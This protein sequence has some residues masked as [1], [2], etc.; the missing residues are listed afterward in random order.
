MGIEI[1]SWLIAIP[2]LG[3]ATGMRSMT[4]MA[5]LCWFAYLGNLSMEGTWAAWTGRRYVAIV[6]TVLAVGELV[7]DKLPKIPAR[8]SFAP[9][10]WRFLLGGLAGSI[11]ATSLNGPGVEGVLL[12]LGGVAVGAFGGYMVRRDLGE[13]FAC[14]DWPVA[15]A[16]DLMAV[17]FSIYALH[18]ITT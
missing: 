15:I 17:V 2:L 3:V 14:V 6:L 12:A 11:A 7:A 8:I 1:L 13:K 18:V 10:I 5:V 4:P 16:E 9:L